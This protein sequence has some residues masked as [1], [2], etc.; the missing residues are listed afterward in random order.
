MTVH[1]MVILLYLTMILLIGSMI[2][3]IT[4]DIQNG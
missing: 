4:L 2:H 3:L 1:L